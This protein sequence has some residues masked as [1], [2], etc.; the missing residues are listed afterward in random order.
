[1]GESLSSIGRR[2]T[3]KQHRTD[4]D[5]HRRL[6]SEESC[7]SQRYTAQGQEA[8]KK[9]R[10]NFSKHGIQKFASKIRQGHRKDENSYT[11]RH[12]QLS[13]EPSRVSKGLQ[14]CLPTCESKSLINNL[15]KKIETLENTIYKSNCQNDRRLTRMEV[16]INKTF[17]RLSDVCQSNNNTRRTIEPHDE[18]FGDD[19]SR[20]EFRVPDFPIMSGRE[21]VDLTRKLKNLEFKSFLVIFKFSFSLC[22]LFKRKQHFRLIKKRNFALRVKQK[23]TMS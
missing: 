9:L 12:S 1:M 20:R 17:I 15:I 23:R 21:L 3:Q 13:Y 7:Q 6:S 10:S 4:I 14:S 22:H 11:S 2:Q 18:V 19:S 16:T 5:R 8:V